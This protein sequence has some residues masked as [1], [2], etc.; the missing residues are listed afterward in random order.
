MANKLSRLGQTIHSEFQPQVDLFA[1]RFNNKLPP[2]VS[3]VPDPQ[4]WAVDAP[5]LPWENMDP[6]AFPPVAIVG[7]VVEKL[8]D[9]PCNR[10]PQHA[11]VLGP[12]D[13]TQS[14]PTVSAQPAGLI[15][16]SFNQTLHNLA[17]LNLHAWVLEP[18]P[19]RRKAS[20]MQWKHELR[21]FKEDQPDQFMRQSGP[22]LQSGASVIRWTSGHHFENHS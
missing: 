8:Q 22:F 21:L 6:Y 12:V 5:S 18:Q 2:F 17:N 4:T 15:A 19:S 20:L 3:P 14:D 13:Y 9:Y 16:Q 10:V 1:I 7:K 11:L